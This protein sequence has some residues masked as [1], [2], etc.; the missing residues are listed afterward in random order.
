[1]KRM[2]KT[3]IDLALSYLYT[4][5]EVAED[6]IKKMHITACECRE[7]IAGNCTCPTEIAE[8]IDKS[9]EFYVFDKTFTGLRLIERSMGSRPMTR[10]KGKK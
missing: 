7:N 4:I 2:E 9:F 3:L 6:K 5:P 8:A 10:V 1:M